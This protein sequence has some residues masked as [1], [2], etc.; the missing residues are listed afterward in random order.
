MLIEQEAPNNFA[1]F[2]VKMLSVNFLRVLLHLYQKDSEQIFVYT[3]K[4]VIGAG[5]LSRTIFMMVSYFNI[6]VIK[7]FG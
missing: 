7:Y 6:T 3:R 1:V 4:K 5:G 2:W